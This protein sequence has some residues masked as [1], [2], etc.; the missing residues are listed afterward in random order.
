MTTI[1]GD[2]FITVDSILGALGA[3]AVNLIDDTFALI[4]F[5]QR[6][7]S[8]IIPNVVIEEIGSDQLRITD[9][10]VEIGAAVT[11]HAFKMPVELEMKAGWSDSSGQQAG[12]IRQI[13]N[14]LIALQAGREPF[15]LYSGKRV[16]Q[17]ML[18]AGLI[19]ATDYKSENA[20]QTT[21]R[22]REILLTYTTQAAG[23]QQGVTPTTPSAAG[24][25]IGTNSATQ[26]GEIAGVI[27][28]SSAGTLQ[29][30]GAAGSSSAALF[31]Q[32]A[33]VQ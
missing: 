14:Q 10:P 19:Q 7:F 12:Y 9:H 18:L 20:L 31:G 30:I 11:D 4:S 32:I 2:A 5:N 3:N 29:P 23:S 13:Y 8:G 15:T 16:Y 6:S 21:L 17:N 25:T 33:G 28:S 22:F 26:F 27:P 1:I 24:G